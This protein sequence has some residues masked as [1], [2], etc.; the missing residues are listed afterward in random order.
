M[1]ANEEHRPRKSACA[2]RSLEQEQ[3]RVARL[4]IEERIKRSLS[5]GRRFAWL[6]PAPI[7]DTDQ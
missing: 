5:M 3:E 2:T 4:S 6:A 1:Q 7:K